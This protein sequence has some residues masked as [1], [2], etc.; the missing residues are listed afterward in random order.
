MTHG[1]NVL[2]SPA[3]HGL[4]RK[5]S[6]FGRAENYTA[7]FHN[8]RLLVAV[9][10]KVGIIALCLCTCVSPKSKKTLLEFPW[11]KPIRATRVMGAAAGW[12]G[13]NILEL[14]M[15]AE[16]SGHQV[17]THLLMLFLPFIFGKVRGRIARGRHPQNES[18]EFCRHCQHQ[19]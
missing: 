19:P 2:L 17:G 13:C 14:A 6:L 18:F 9:C 4:I 10:G 8:P 5:K 15:I 3:P 16:Y 11:K 7:C 1:F 12:R